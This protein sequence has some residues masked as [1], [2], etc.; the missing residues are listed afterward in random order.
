MTPNELLWI[1][2]NLTLLDDGVAWAVPGKKRRLGVKLTSK[3]SAHDTVR[4]PYR[5]LRV[6][7]IVWYLATG[8]WPDKEI[9]H[10]DRNPKNN[11]F[12]NLRLVSRSANNANKRAPETNTSG[13]IGVVKVKRR[14][15][16]QLGHN[17][18][19]IVVGTFSCP[20]L[21]A[22]ARDEMALRVYGPNVLLNKEATCECG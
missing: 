11:C 19:N 14:W 17:N 4:S 18:K 22:L 6:H 8:Q 16:A 1:K 3:G 21:A 7:H 5:L 20:E 15:R 12:S 10:I 2:A 9:D 13:Y